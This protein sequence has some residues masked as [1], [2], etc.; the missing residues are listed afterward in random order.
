MNFQRAFANRI[1]RIARDVE[2]NGRWRHF[3]AVALLLL[4]NIT[5]SRKLWLVSFTNQLGSVE[6]SYISISR[7]AL[8]HCGDLNWFPVWFCGIPFLQV[9]QPGLHLTLP[10]LAG[11]LTTPP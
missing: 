9:Y 2:A 11:F 6:G 4:I 8:H 1:G 3:C 10:A 5:V 7:Y